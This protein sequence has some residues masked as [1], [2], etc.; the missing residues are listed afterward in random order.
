VFQFDNK[1][2]LIDL[3]HTRRLRA[4]IKKITGS[5][6]YRPAEVETGKDY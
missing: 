3:G 2:A 6:T 4:K 1:L 5:P